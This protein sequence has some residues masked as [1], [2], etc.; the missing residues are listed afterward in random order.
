MAL[1]W[2][3]KTLLAK[4]ETVYG[5]DPAPTGAANAILATNVTLSPMEGTDVSRELE[6]PAFGAQPTIAAELH[7]TLKFM[8]ELQASGALGVAPAWGP[9]LRACA[10]AQVIV[11]TTSVTYNPITNAQES[12]TL[13]LNVDGTLFNLKGARGDVTLMLDAQGIPH[14]EFTF[15]GLFVQPAAQAKPTA[16]LSGFIDPTVATT[17]NTPVFTL[18][19]F[20]PKV[21]SFKLA[22]GNQVE[23]RF[24]IGSEEILITDHA[25]QIEFQIEA[26]ALAT[27]NPFALAVSGAPVALTMR[28][29]T[30]AGKRV[31]ANVPKMQ[32]QRP[33]SLAVQQNVVEW[34]LR[35]VPQ[36]T[37]G[38]DQWTLVLT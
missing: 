19:A 5:T 33:Q 38:N 2:R 18:D 22:A 14:L 12:V 29:G 37:A 20:S 26:E 8:V 10:F 16:V 13:Y 34:A 24:L 30:V 36:Q 27:W 3:N 21:R 25:E 17:A 6:L 35:G 11:A 28:H 9:L 23:R 31:Q 7:A 1:F 32:I 15:T 4:I